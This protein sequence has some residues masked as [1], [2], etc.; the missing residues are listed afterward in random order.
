M[1]SI[2]VAAAIFFLTLT[3]PEKFIEDC[4]D[5]ELSNQEK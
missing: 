5:E 3:K 4:I 1:G 2:A